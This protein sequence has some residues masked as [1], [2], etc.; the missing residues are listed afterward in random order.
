MNQNQLE[1]DRDYWKAQHM[2]L[3]G[4]IQFFVGWTLVCILII[5]VEIIINRFWHVPLH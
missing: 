3:K 4:Q 5:T 2:K 1:C